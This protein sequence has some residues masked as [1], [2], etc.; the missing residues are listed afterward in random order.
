MCYFFQETGISFHLSFIWEHGVYCNFKKVN[1][2]M[3]Q[4]AGH[5]V[6]KPDHVIAVINTQLNG[7]SCL[8][9][10]HRYLRQ[11]TD[12]MTSH[13]TIFLRISTR[14]FVWACVLFLLLS[15]SKNES[16]PK[17]AIASINPTE[18]GA[19]TI[20]TITGTNFNTSVSSNTVLINNIQAVIQQVTATSLSVTVPDFAGT[21]TVNVTSN[22]TTAIGPTFNYLDIFIAGV[23]NNS[24]NNGIAKYWKNGIETLLTDG[25]NNA[26]AYSIVIANK[27]IY[28]AGYEANSNGISVAKYW[29]NGTAVALTDGSNEYVAS[30]ILVNGTDVYVCG[31]GVGSATYW[32]NGVAV[33]LTDGTHLAGASSMVVSGTDVYVS[34]FEYGADYSIAK[35][36]KNGTSVE[37][38]DGSSNARGNDLA[39]LGSDVYVA[40]QGYSS[41][42]PHI[43]EIWKNGSSFQVGTNFSNSF[44]I[45]IEGNDIYAAGYSNGGTATY[46]KNNTPTILNGSMAYAIAINSSD[47]YVAGSSGIQAVYWKNGSLTNLTTDP[48]NAVA[49]SIFLFN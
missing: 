44:A 42:L 27:D 35:Y 3:L 43:A 32:K 14:S 13:S 40:G 21:G 36:W 19:G 38:S 1:H 26:G 45:A 39:L 46:W 15:C 7:Y 25:T 6:S 10:N 24:N 22:G 33:A 8:E 30:A 29:K 16:I 34:G 47:I 12:A 37:L 11:K 5:P 49:Y 17:P 28:V 31:S 41:G 23:E 20:L 9:K 2:L 48:E 18:G 4:L